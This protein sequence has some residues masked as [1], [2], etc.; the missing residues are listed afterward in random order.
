MSRID[1]NSAGRPTVVSNQSLEHVFIGLLPHIDRV[2]DWLAR[3]YRLSAADAQDFGQ[4]IKLKFIDND[5]DLL[6]RFQERSTLTT[7]VTSVVTNAFHDYRNAAW[8]KWRPSAEARRLGPT[9]IALEQCL[10]R[11]GM[12]FEEACERLSTDAPVD[13]RALEQVAALLPIRV[14]RRFETEDALHAV[15]T[16]ETADAIVR[17]RERLSLAESIHA[18]LARALDRLP[19]ED[20]AILA[21]K[22]RSGRKVSEIAAILG[23]PQKPLYRRIAALLTDLRV[24]LEREGLPATVVKEYLSD[25]A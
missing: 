20:A 21:L 4:S 24:S 6:R 14:R 10:V 16:A 23:L 18:A 13:H 8:G 1:Y 9:A 25:E 12:T 7:F 3:R 11:D 17:D 5:Y 22:F 15:A 19:A 2:T